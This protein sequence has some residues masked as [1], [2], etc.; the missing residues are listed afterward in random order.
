MRKLKKSQEN[1][2][3]VKIKYPEELLEEV[4]KRDSWF[5]NSN[6]YKENLRKRLIHK[7]CFKCHIGI[8]TVKLVWKLDGCE[9]HEY[10]CEDCY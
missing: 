8:P 6:I 3:V 7:L 1:P 10:Y 9:K 2:R 5:P 4:R